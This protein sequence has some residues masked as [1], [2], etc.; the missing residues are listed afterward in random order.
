MRAKWPFRA[1]LYTQVLV[2]RLPLNSGLFRWEYECFPSAHPFTIVL[3]S[4]TARSRVP[5]KVGPGMAR[6]LE[7]QGIVTIR[8]TLVYRH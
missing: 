2:P 5:M 7:L 8:V 3:S 6:H 1:R 4:L